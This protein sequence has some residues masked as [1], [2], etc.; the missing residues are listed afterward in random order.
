M[1]TARWVPRLVST[2][3]VASTASDADHDDKIN[4]DD[5]RAFYA[6]FSSSAVDED[7][8]R[9]MMSATDNNGFVQ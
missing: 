7:L 4:K 2:N 3:T 6:G 5:L 8:T 9:S 1:T